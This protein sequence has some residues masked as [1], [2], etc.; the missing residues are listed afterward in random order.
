M[1]AS[2]KGHVMTIKAATPYLTLGGKGDEAIGF[3]QRAL[4][5]KLE[6]LQRFGDV[7]KS[8]PESL[9]HW[10]MHAQLQVGSALL[11]LSDGSPESKPAPGGTVNVA[12]DIDNAAQARECFAALSEGGSV[13]QPLIEAPWGALFGALQDRFGV[14]WMFNSAK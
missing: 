1:G 11:M 14:N 5:A 9:K 7:D 10:V 13:F 6:S 4:G 2:F 12:L 3:Y 8:C